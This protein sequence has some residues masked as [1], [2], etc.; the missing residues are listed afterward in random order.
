MPTAEKYQYMRR[1]DDR[2]FQ[3]QII[4]LDH[5]NL[6][7]TYHIKKGLTSG[8]ELTSVF[9][10]ASELVLTSNLELPSDLVLTSNLELPLGVEL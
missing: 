3:H 10:L 7:G 1:L 6:C 5:C 2:G 4:S 9:E 8:F